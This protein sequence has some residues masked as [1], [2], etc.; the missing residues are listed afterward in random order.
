MLLRKLVWISE[1]PKYIYWLDT[2]KTVKLKNSKGVIGLK[3]TNSLLVSLLF[4]AK[5]NHD[6]DPEDAISNYEFS[7]TKSVIMQPDESITICTNKSELLDIL[8]GPP[9][10]KNHQE[11]GTMPMNATALSIDGMCTVNEVIFEMCSN[12]CKDLADVFTNVLK[13]KK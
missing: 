9:S 11:S 7:T 6:K 12:T 10:S 2:Y 13:K 1:E 4:I 5:S 3:S 8:E